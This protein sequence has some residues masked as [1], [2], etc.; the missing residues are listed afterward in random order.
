[1][2]KVLKKE[3]LD[4]IKTDPDLFHSVCKAMDVTPAYLPV[5]LS[6][7][8][9][10]INKYSIVTLIASYLRRDPEDLLEE[11]KPIGELK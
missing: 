3:V 5:A 6:R 9:N 8:G 2:A 11:E 1:M 4:K 10:T 7:N